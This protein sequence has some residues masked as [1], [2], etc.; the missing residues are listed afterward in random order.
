MYNDL[1]LRFGLSF[2]VYA[3]IYG[4]LVASIIML[5]FIPV[6]YYNWMKPADTRRSRK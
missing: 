3:I 2:L 1:L 5:L 6:V 4:L